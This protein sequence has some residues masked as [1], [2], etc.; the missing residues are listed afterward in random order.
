MPVKPLAQPQSKTSYLI[1]TNANPVALSYKHR[2]IH[3]KVVGGE[4]C[5]WCAVFF[6]QRNAKFK[7]Y[8]LC[9]FAIG[10]VPVTAAQ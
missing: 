9:I 1:V 6:V 10:F 8:G 4:A 2:Q 5:R 3:I 7:G